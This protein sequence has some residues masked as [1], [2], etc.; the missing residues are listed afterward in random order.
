MFINRALMCAGLL[1]VLFLANYAD[2][3]PTLGLLDLEVG[4]KEVVSQNS[5]QM[6]DEFI[7]E[8]P[9]NNIKQLSNGKFVLVNDFLNSH[10]LDS[11]DQ[12]L[13]G[14]VLEQPNKHIKQLSTGNVVLV[15]EFP[16]SHNLKTVN[17]N[18]SVY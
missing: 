7:L 1:V 12:I 9:N 2:A 3:A 5:N 11:N 17:I 10:N 13:E 18:Y 16:N 15:K 8:Q 14:I 6:L 4:K